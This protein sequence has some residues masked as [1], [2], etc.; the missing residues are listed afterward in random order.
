MFSKAERSSF[1]YWFA[2]YCA[3]NM[4]ALNCKAWKFK[5]LFHDIEKPFLK[6]FLP[7]EKVQKIHRKHN[8][9]HPEWLERQLF[10]LTDKYKWIVSKALDKVD[11]EGMII[12]WEC[13]HFTKSECP[14]LAFEEY[15]NLIYKPTFSEKYPWITKYC[16]DEFSKRLY[17]T[18]IKLGLKN[19]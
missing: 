1:P 6:L 16:Y 19:V 10:G 11:F 18:I 4:T 12:D 9:H 3:Y 5:Y 13:S 17:D 7:Y 8:K 2:H 15:R 14:Y